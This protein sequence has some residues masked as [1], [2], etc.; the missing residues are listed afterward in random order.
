MAM[1]VAALSGLMAEIFDD[2]VKSQINRTAPLVSL[3][4]KRMATGK[5][6][7]WDAKLGTAGSG[8]QNGVIADGTAPSNFPSDT[9]KPASLEYGTYHG[10]FS[11]TPKT[12]AYAAAARNPAELS[13]IF[14]DEFGDCVERLAIDVAE[15]IYSGNGAADTIAGLS[16]AVDSTG[17]YAGIDRAVD[18]QWAASEID[19]TV[20]TNTLVKDMRQLRTAIYKASALPPDLWVMD[21][22]TFEKYGDTFTDRRFNQDVYLRGQKITLDAGYSALEFDGIPV[23][24]DVRCPADTV[25]CLNTRHVY[26]QQLPDPNNPGNQGQMTEL[27]A[28]MDMEQTLSGRPGLM[29]RFIPLAF[30]GGAYKFAL[31]VY[32][33][34]AVKRPNSC[35][36]IINVA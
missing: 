26:M 23:I 32:P 7:Q 18:A 28:E 36:K 4:P 9:R 20:S 27:S 15:D 34:L 22:D 5:N 10:A 24:Q 12:M 31:Y 2:E 1:N 16:L 8:G 3:L 14:M 33:Q 30:D 29:A 21:P 6:I 17:T 25:F 11:I 13:N 19:N 35:G